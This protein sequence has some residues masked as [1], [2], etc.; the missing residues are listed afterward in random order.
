MDKVTNQDARNHRMKT[1]VLY[2]MNTD[3]VQSFRNE[4]LNME[5]GLVLRRVP[6]VNNAW[7]DSRKDID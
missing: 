5:L 6:S 4:N 1:Y 7:Q 2:R 3:N